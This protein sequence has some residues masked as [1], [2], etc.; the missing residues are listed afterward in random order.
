VNGNLIDLTGRRFGKLEV[1]SLDHI[2][3]NGSYWLCQCECENTH[4]A[5]AHCL[6]TGHTTSCGCLYYSARGHSKERLYTTW[7]DMLRRCGNPKCK[8]YS[9]YGGRGITVCE[10]WKADYLNFKAWSLSSGYRDTL[11]IDRINSSGNYE[12][13]NCQWATM[14]MQENNTRNNRIVSYNNET[15][16]VAEWAE[17]IG[18]SY[19]TISG[20]LNRSWTMD[21]I[22][23]TSQQKRTVKCNA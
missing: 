2:N 6:K 18:I 15:H 17:I 1:I 11:T 7:K 22:S 12:P 4:V 3:K 20:R 19:A 14:K 8:S 16:T 9:N 5:S 21:R 13:L 23:K 10:E